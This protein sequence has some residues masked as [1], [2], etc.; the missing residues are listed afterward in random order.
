[1]RVRYTLNPEG[2][3][4]EVFNTSRIRI[5]PMIPIG[6]IIQDRITNKMNCTISKML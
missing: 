1:M 3:N 5:L 2:G 6:E 4:K